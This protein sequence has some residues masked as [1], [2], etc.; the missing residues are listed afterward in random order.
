MRTL[1]LSDRIEQSIFEENSL[2]IDEIPLSGKK[3]YDFD[4]VVCDRN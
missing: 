1:N 3:V 2:R 4:L